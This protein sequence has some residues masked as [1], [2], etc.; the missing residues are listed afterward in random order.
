MEFR[1]ETPLTREA[2]VVFLHRYRD[3]AA[4]QQ[5]VRA[6]DPT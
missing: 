5:D 1:P 2:A 4:R 3:W 6:P